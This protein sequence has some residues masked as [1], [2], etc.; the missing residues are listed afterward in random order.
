MRNYMKLP[1]LI[2]GIA[3]LSASNLGAGPQG[4]EWPTVIQGFAN[5][6][7]DTISIKGRLFDSHLYLGA[8]GDHV[9]FDLKGQ[10]AAFEA[11]AGV[12]EGVV[13]NGRIQFTVDGEVVKKLTVRAGE[14]PVPVSIN[15]EGARSFR[16]DAPQDAFDRGTLC[17]PKFLK[18]RPSAPKVSK[19]LSPMDGASIR[20][21]AVPLVW[22]PVSGATSYGIEIVA[23]RL[24]SPAKPRDPRIWAAT[25][26]EKPTHEFD[27]T[28][29]P[30]GEYRWSVIAYDDVNALGAF[31]SS[32]RLVL[33]AERELNSDQWY[34]N[35]N[36][37]L[38]VAK[39]TNRL[40][41]L[42]FYTDW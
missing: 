24:D 37:A 11:M 15:L 5:L 21:G 33:Q 30:P 13:V 17:E 8:L 31:S 14:A 26:D 41:M 32:T 25:T 38:E 10:Y 29:L 3:V 27:F 4:A 42:D 6:S 18:T 7:S 34:E 2:A 23:V 19:N 9:I 36:G 12:E 35:L 22:Q 20:R 16:I 1:A 39:R 28:N 40:V